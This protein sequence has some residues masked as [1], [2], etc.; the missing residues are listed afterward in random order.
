MKKQ[1]AYQVDESTGEIIDSHI[2]PFVR[3]PW[4]Y[5]RD[6]VS[7]ETGTENEEPTLAQ[8]H[9]KDECDINQILEKFNV[10]GVVPT[11]VR[12]PINQD[13]IETMDYQTS[14]NAIMEAEAA[15]MEMPAKVRAEFENDPGKFIQ[16][17]EREENRERAVALGLIKGAPEA[18]KPPETPS[19]PRAE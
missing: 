15:F 19:A 10:T 13:F 17:F 4:N 1:T 5:N 6:F 14:L 8:Q 12:Q 16:F 9:F 3:T 11:N 2:P 18:P 7:R